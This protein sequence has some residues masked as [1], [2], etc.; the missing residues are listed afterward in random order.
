MKK[1]GLVLLS[2]GL[3][4]GSM[5]QKKKLG[6]FVGKRQVGVLDVNKSV[7]GDAIVYHANSKVD[8]KVGFKVNV[9]YSMNCKYEEGT[10]KQSN[11]RV[12]RG[13]KLKT[14]TRVKRAPNSKGYLVMNNKEGIWS[15]KDKVVYSGAELYY[16]EPNHVDFVFSELTGKF[17]PVK[18]VGAKTY[19]LTDLKNNRKSVY[20]YNDKGE[21]EEVVIHE[22]LVKFTYRPID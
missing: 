1:V 11:V 14:D 3:S 10:L 13:G 17:N 22:S 9:D 12:V 5:A 7:E 18:K 21:V 2:L 20:T 4:F 6:I 15:E 16:S 19:E 8:V